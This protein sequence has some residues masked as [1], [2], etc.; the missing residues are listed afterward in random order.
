M[1]PLERELLLERINGWAWDLVKIQD[2]E[3]KDRDILI[4]NLKLDI[5]DLKDTLKGLN[6]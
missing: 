1:T 5:M 6:L 2:C 3:Q 4:Q